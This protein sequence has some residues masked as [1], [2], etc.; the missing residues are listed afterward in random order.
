MHAGTPCTLS[1]GQSWRIEQLAWGDEAVAAA[2]LV[3]AFAEDPLV[4]AICAEPE[5]RRAEKM[6]W[7]FRLSLR[8]H[9]LSPQPAWVIRMDDG[10]IGGV[11]LVSEPGGRL[12]RASDTLFSL[13]A[14][15]HIGWATAQRG[16]EAARAIAQ[17]L[18][19]A[20]FLYVRT[21]GVDPEVQHCGLGSTLLTYALNACSAAA[22]AYLETA[23]AKNLRFYA[24]H[25]FHCIGTFT[26]LGVCVWRLWRPAS[27]RSLP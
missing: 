1:S 14:L 4:R 16:V 26:A 27:C 21:L 7:S 18:P 23:V 13:R 3:R 22:P 6:W 25:G 24:R 12:P 11:V 2:T 10:T 17:H 15:W 19:K 8:A 9:C 5:G 20:P